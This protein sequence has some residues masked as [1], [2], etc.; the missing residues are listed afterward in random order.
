MTGPVRIIAGVCLAV[1]IFGATGCEPPQPAQFDKPAL[2]EVY[3]VAVL[4]MRS[5][6][7]GVGPVASGMTFTYLVDAK[8]PQL[9]VAAAPALR[10]LRR[11]PEKLTPGIAGQAGREIGVD[12]V[13]TG[14][15]QYVLPPLE[16]AEAQTAVTVQILWSQTSEVIYEHTGQGKDKD[17]PAAFAKAIKAAL[18]PLERY[19]RKTRKSR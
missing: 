13:V 7:P 6:T 11:E 8:L 1:A 17:I 14:A 16:G 9:S 18:E 12:A 19:W 15:A 5:S 4:P 3:S 10:R 2:A